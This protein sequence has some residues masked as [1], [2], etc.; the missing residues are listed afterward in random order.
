MYKRTKQAVEEVSRYRSM[1]VFNK[2]VDGLGS[3]P[4]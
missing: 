3:P 1:Q 4:S 2:V